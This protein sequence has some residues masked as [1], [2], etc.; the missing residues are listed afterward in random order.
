[1]FTEKA[2]A[3]PLG[4]HA[5][6][7]HDDMVKGSLCSVILLHYYYIVWFRRLT[8]QMDEHFLRVIIPEGVA[9]HAVAV[10]AVVE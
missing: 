6:Y 5:G 3:L 4:C 9:I 7:T 10:G 1:M 8:S 2:M